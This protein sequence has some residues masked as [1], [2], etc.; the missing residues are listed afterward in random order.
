MSD[1]E[2]SGLI[3]DIKANNGLHDAIVLHDGMILDGRNRYRACC[4]LGIEPMTRPWDGKGDPIDYVIYKNLHRRLLHET[5]RGV[6]ADKI[7]TLRDG[8]RAD[9][10]GAQI[11]APTQAQAAE[12]LNVSRRTVQNARTIREKGIP[13][14]Q[15]AVAANQ[16]SLSA[17]SQVA[18]M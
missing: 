14:L 6:V 7:A 18:K 9:R 12:R 2:L 13:E 3:E 1:D 11:C 10:Q 4:K 15:A 8:Q 16:V 17:A 5:Q